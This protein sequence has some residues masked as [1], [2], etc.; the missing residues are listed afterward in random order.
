M[1][2][3][4]NLRREI[5]VV[6]ANGFEP[7]TSWSRTGVSKNLKPCGCRTYK[8]RHPKNPASI[9]PHLVHNYSACCLSAVPGLASIGWSSQTPKRTYPMIAFGLMLCG[10][11]GSD[12]TVRNTAQCCANCSSL[13]NWLSR[14]D[15][16]ETRAGQDW[17]DIPL[18]PALAMP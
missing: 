12:T 4:S 5:E 3:N 13:S 6:G 16:R 1:S 8:H 2:R 18:F 9:G 14:D 11:G 15:C 10:K 7:S 17:R